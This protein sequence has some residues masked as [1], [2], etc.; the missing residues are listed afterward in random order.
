MGSPRYSSSLLHMYV[1]GIENV[2]K[3]P[4]AGYNS[5]KKNRWR[6]KSLIKTNKNVAQPENHKLK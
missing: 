6:L 5:L 3:D 1:V 2:I 4:N